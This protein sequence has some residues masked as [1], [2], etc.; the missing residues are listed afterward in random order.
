AGASAARDRG[1]RLSAPAGL[2]FHRPDAAPETLP[3]HARL[4]LAFAAA[5]ARTDAAEARALLAPALAARWTAEALQDAFDA[6]LARDREAGPVAP[7]RVF[8]GSTDPM[9]GWPHRRPEHAGWAYVAVEGT[10]AD[11]CAYSEAVSVEVVRV[12]AELRVADVSWGRP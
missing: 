3:D 4:G 2:T 6:M 12:G 8:V 9:D 5:L 7:P 1:G 10:D 11:G